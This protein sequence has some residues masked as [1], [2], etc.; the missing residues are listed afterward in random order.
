MKL[1]LH[2][3]EVKVGEKQSAKEATYGGYSRVEA[4]DDAKAVH[5]PA[6]TDSG[7]VLTHYSIAD[8]KKD[9]ITEV[10]ELKPPTL[11]QNG[12]APVITL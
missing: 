9:V 4:K 6:S 10:G 3:A 7:E 11:T 12:H 5:F 1:A 8:D 2:T